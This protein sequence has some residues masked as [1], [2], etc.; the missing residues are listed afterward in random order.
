MNSKAKKFITNSGWMMGQ[1]IY[2]MVL[3]L[4]VGALSARYLGPSNYGLLNYGAS[5]ISFFTI[6]SRL[7]IDGVI[8]NEMLKK[9]EKKGSYLGSALIM[10]LLTSIASLFVIMAIIRVIAPGNT[11]LYI[12]TLFQS[13]AIIIQTYEVVTYWF[14]LNLKMKYV[15]IATMIALTA[16]AVWRV[17]LLATESTVYFF[18]LSASVQYLV[19]GIV[20]VLFF[21]KQKEKEF[22]LSW[23]TIDAKFLLGN[24]YHFIISGIAVTFYMQI[25]KIMIGKMI[26]SEAVG[27]Y[28]AATTV[29]ALWEF[30]PNALVSSARPIIIEEQGRNKQ[31]YLKRFQQLLAGITVLFVSV[32]VAMMIF[33]RLAVLILYGKKYIDAVVPL[34]ILIWSTGF[35]MIGTARGVWIVAEGLNRYTKYY[36]FIG[37]GVN[38][39]LNFF[40]IRSWGIIGAAITTLISQIVVALIAPLAF[41]KT[42]AFT[43]IYFD[44]LKEISS[45]FAL[46][47]QR[48][49]K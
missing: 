27:I 37:A 32:S 42:K 24:S 8:I 14:Q 33:G 20:V 46:I 31:L 45:T 11:D 34:C 49:A 23:N 19:C 9:P 4:V 10:R 5:I 26:S 36:V 39:V 38:F 40:F 47:K 15:S 48:F 6:I 44:S 25:D 30:V 21:I 18:A 12:V 13:F 3:S 29:A 35:A 7:G 22:K 41:S 43:K 28:T 16:T 2:S 1:Q 17:T